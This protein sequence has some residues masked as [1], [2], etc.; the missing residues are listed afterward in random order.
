MQASCSLQVTSSTHAQLT[1]FYPC[2]IIFFNLCLSRTY[3]ELIFVV[4]ANLNS[5]CISALAV[6]SVKSAPYAGFVLNS[7]SQYIM[8]NFKQAKQEEQQLQNSQVV[9]CE[10]WLNP[11]IGIWQ[12]C[13]LCS[14]YYVVVSYHRM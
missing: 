12:A 7:D 8:C 13:L 9:G 5:N 10:F 6:R 14:R 11:A 3:G 4:V 1:F 2:I